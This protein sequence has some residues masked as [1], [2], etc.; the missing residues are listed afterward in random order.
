MR[1]DGFTIL[2]VLVALAILALAMAAILGAIGTNLAAVAR[3]QALVRATLAAQSV[4]AGAGLDEALRP[5]RQSGVLPDGS[6]WSLEVRA[7]NH[8]LVVTA[9][10]DPPGSG[11]RVRLVTLR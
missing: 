5:G 4:L 3:A 6:G 9:T 7:E 10:V 2:E 8:V 1:A 11:G